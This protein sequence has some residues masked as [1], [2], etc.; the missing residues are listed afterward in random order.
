M[1]LF[2]EKLLGSA[3][4]KGHQVA[5]SQSFSWDMGPPEEHQLDSH[6]LQPLGVEVSS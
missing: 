5:G 6:S 2:Q 1:V 4:L 3:T